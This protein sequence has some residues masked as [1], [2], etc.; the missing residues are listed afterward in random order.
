MEVNLCCICPTNAHMDR[1]DNGKSNSIYSSRPSESLEGHKNTAQLNHYSYCT[2]STGALVC[3]FLQV[4]RRARSARVIY[5]IVGHLFFL[6]LCG[7]GRANRGW[8]LKHKERTF[9][10]TRHNAVSCS[11]RTHWL[12]KLTVSTLT[13]I[14]STLICLMRVYECVSVWSLSAGS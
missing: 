6:F 5:P 1:E 8:S 12:T 2:K 14:T 4:S 13:Q 3:S 7:S 9:L 11:G 10:H